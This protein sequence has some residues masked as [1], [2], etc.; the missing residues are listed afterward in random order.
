MVAEQK[1]AV[2]AESVDC[3]ACDGAISL[4]QYMIGSPLVEGSL[5]Y[6][7]GTECLKMPAPYG[8]MVRLT[9]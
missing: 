8:Q 9:S 2:L 7:L 6:L 3:A 1:P 4:A 5:E